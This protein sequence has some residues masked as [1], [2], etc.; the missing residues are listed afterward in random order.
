MEG[1]S[2]NNLKA[3]IEDSKNRPLWRLLNALGIRHVGVT[4]SKDIS[5]HIQVF[6]DLEKWSVEQLH[7]Y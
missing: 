4:T 7:Q 3:G 2:L 1:K 6:F 5:T